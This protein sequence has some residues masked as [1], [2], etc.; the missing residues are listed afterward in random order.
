MIIM[1]PTNKLMSEVHNEKKRMP[2]VLVREDHD[3]WLAG[4]ERRSRWKR[5][6]NHDEN[7]SGGIYRCAE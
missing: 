3:A 1:Q 5:R 4:A 7:G 6:V 2:S